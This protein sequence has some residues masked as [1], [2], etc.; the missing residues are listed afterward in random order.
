MSSMTEKITV[1]TT[2]CPQCQILIKLL[3]QKEIGYSIVDKEDE[4]RSVAAEAN[5]TTVPFCR[6]PGEQNLQTFQETLVYINSL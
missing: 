1:Y 6:I 4:V 3:D 5:I 2:H